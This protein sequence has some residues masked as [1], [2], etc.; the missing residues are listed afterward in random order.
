MTVTEQQQQQQSIET[1][2]TKAV[3]NFAVPAHVRFDEADFEGK[4]DVQDLSADGGVKKIILGLG[5]NKDGTWFKPEEG[6]EVQVLYT[7]RLATRHDGSAGEMF[8]QNENR[9]NPFTFTLGKGA[10]V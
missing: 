8:D 7:G 6:D 3:S 1:I 2:P 5:A 9:D 10:V 4:G